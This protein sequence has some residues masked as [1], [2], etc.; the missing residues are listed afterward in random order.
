MSSG[1]QKF[2]IQP[3]D[4]NPPQEGGGLNPGL[5]GG[6]AGAFQAKGP[7]IPAQDVLSKL[8]APLSKEEL[9]K[10]QEELNKE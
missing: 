10:R 4:G 9:K 8:D 3:V 6:A 2:T 7:H 1:E 5:Q